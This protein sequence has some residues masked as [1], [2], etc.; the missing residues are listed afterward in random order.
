MP[1]NKA[2]GPWYWSG[3]RRSAKGEHVGRDARIEKLDLEQLIVDDAALPDELIQARLHHGTVAL[4][5]HVDA[6]ARLQK[7]RAE[8]AAFSRREREVMLLVTSGLLHKQ[9]GSRL[10]ISEIAVKAH[11]GKMMRKMEA[12]S[13]PDLVI[14]AAMLGLSTPPSK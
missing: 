3:A 7:L 12:S 11:R 10:G 13:L 2:I 4:P 5:V 8:Y 1:S 9:V 14:K 6:E